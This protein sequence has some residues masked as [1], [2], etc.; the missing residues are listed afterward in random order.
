MTGI[1][2]GV[3]SLSVSAV[4]ASVN[5]TIWKGTTMENTQT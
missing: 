1:V 2:Q 3:L 4:F 5:M